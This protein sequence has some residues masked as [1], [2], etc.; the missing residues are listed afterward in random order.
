MRCNECNERISLKA[1][2]CGACGAPVAPNEGPSTA[3]SETKEYAKDVLAEG[4]IVAKEAALMAK[5]GLKTDIGKSVAACA[6]VGAV[7]AV[8]IPF[9]GPVLGAAV[10][11][12][13]GLFRK[14]V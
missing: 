7:I 8:P 10:G 2:F 1:K 13:I 4:K 6:A 11:A 9:V 3:I 5:N 14:I 12:S